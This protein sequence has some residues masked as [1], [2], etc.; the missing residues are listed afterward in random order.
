MVERDENGNLPPL[1]VKDLLPDALVVFAC[2]IGPIILIFIVV[3]CFCRASRRK[4]KALEAEE[5]QKQGAKRT[6][7]LTKLDSEMQ[8]L[9]DGAETERRRTLGG[10][11]HL[12]F[13]PARNDNDDL[14][15]NMK[16]IKED[17]LEQESPEPTRN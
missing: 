1:L 4:R 10:D 15:L 8:T 5:Q 9:E 11:D 12:A 16:D 14:R 7:T 3:T 17:A 2:T 13:E 6:T